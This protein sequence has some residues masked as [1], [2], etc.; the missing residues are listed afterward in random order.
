MTAALY[1]MMLYME[2]STDD[3][4]RAG[5]AGARPSTSGCWPPIALIG[6]QLVLTTAVALFFSTFSTPLLSMLFTLGVWVAGHFSADLRNFQTAVDS[7]VAI[8]VARG[9]Y[10][11]LPN[12]AA[13]DV[14]NAIVHGLDVPWRAVLVGVL[15]LLAY[16]G[17]LLAAAVRIFERR[18][19][20]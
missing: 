10:Y 11:V 19:F 7:P 2:W 5:L 16:A 12:L 13:V 8:A 14:K 6:V 20:K 1:V 17:L 15:S 18:D 3:W 9:L 4:I